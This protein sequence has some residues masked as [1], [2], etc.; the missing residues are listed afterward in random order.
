MDDQIVVLVSPRTFARR[1]EK[2]PHN[3]VRYG[4]VA[5][6]SLHLDT[7]RHGVRFDFHWCFSIIYLKTTWRSFGPWSGSTSDAFR[8]VRRAD[9]VYSFAENECGPSCATPEFT[10]PLS[11]A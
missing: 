10:A 5:R 4:H 7:L 11:R 8:R 6:W 3:A 1:F 9:V 2:V